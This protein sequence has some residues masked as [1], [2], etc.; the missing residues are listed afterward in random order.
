MAINYSWVIE[1]L[2]SYPEKDGRTDVV[3]KINW[4]RNAEDQGVTAT[5]FGQQ[6]IAFNPENPF[7]AFP[8]LTEAEVVSW[9]EAALGAARVDELNSILAKKIQDQLNP[10][11]VVLPPPWQQVIV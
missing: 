4:R 1:A 7:V 11:V 10:P 5:V 9:L 6:D 8:N 3:H 2:I